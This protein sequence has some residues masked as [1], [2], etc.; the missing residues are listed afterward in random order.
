MADKNAPTPLSD[1]SRIAR[2]LGSQGY[3]ALIAPALTDGERNEI[4]A[5]CGA[6]GT[7]TANVAEVVRPIV[8]KFLAAQKAT[9]DETAQLEETTE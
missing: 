5:C 9:A 2:A 1:D 4:G 7:L 3:S 6:D 8:D